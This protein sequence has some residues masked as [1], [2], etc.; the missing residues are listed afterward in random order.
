MLKLKT[1]QS[2]PQ[3][4]VVAGYDI[5]QHARN[6]NR[7]YLDSLFKEQGFELLGLMKIEPYTVYAVTADG[8][9]WVNYFAVPD[10][11][12]F[13]PASIGDLVHHHQFLVRSHLTT[14]NT[15]IRHL[16]ASS[17][18]FGPDGIT[19]LLELEALREEYHV[20]G[21]HKAV[22]EITFFIKAYEDL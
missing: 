16:Y 20:K 5:V 1:K 11:G 22:D 9:F 13:R 3:S 14:I 12:R 7:S 4:E 15:F 6:V 2:N 17:F 18:D 21:D 19:T 10:A 8:T